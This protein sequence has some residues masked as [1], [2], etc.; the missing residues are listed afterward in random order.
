[1]PARYYPIV[2]NHHKPEMNLVL[3]FYKLDIWL[4]LFS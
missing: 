2:N 1:L 3:P 4:S